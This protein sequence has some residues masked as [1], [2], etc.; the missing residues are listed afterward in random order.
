MNIDELDNKMISFE[1]CHDLSVLPGMYIVARL[2]GRN[3]TKL[4][5]ETFSYEVPFDERFRDYMIETT[6]HLINCGFKVVYGYTQSDE[7]SLM[8]HKDENSYDRK[9]VRIASVLSAEASAKLSN[10][11]GAIAT[12]DCKISELPS[13]EY[14]IDYFT[15]RM[16][17]AQISTLNEYCYWTLRKEGKTHDDVR[18]HMLFLSVADK[19]DLLIRRNIRFNEIPLWQRR[20]VGMYPEKYSKDYIVKSH[21]EPVFNVKRRIIEEFKLPFNDEYNEFIKRL[22]NKMSSEK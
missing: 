20:G 2:D 13:S 19:N 7:I 10:L 15:W 1:T 22:V 3:F 5:K 6:K 18:T 9:L 21:V 17:D 14:L 4:T 8:L 12:F 11:V 16:A